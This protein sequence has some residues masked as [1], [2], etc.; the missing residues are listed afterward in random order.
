MFILFWSCILCFDIWLLHIWFINKYIMYTLYASFFPPL[1]LTRFLWMCNA[2]INMMPWGEWID[3]ED[4]D[5]SQSHHGAWLGIN[6]PHIPQG[7]HSLMLQKTLLEFP[8]RN[9]IIRPWQ[10]PQGCPPPST[11]HWLVHNNSKTTNSPLAV[12]SHIW[13]V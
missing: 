7:P 2:P 4:S 10:N 3:T 13:P 12:Y 5:V 11:S 9:T 6:I 1:N 8:R